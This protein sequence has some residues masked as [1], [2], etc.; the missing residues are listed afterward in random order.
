MFTKFDDV[1]IQTAKLWSSLAK[2][3]KRK[4]C[5]IIAKDDRPI[6][7][8][9]N[10]TL[11]GTNNDCEG[12]YIEC[13]KCKE[14]NDIN[15]NTTFNISNNNSLTIAKTNPY[16]DK[17]YYGFN[18][19]FTCSNC[20]EKIFHDN[21]PET[22]L[23]KK[24]KPTT[25]H[26][27]QNAIFYAAKKGIALDGCTMYVTTSPCIECAKAIASVG[28]KKVIYNDDYK[29]LSGIKYLKDNGITVYKYLDNEDHRETFDNTQNERIK[30]ISNI[31]DKLN[32]A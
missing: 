28:I 4:V 16:I 30:N 6:V 27:E 25:I 3:K 13:P 10:G 11:S 26:A 22:M 17:V 8:G 14:L 20:K 12:E 2:C 32:K 24:T 23:I 9:Y 29:D 21:M 18:V 1:F 15:E 31:R 5:A 19:T 7:N